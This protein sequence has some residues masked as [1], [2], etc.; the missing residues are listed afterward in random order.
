MPTEGVQK[1]YYFVRAAC[2][3]EKK[4]S[5]GYRLTEG[6]DGKSLSEKEYI[7]GAGFKAGLSE[8]TSWCRQEGIPSSCN[9]RRSKTGNIAQ[10]FC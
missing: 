1:R 4:G 3:S 2:M 5:T 6:P 10:H 8:N 9:S 7:L